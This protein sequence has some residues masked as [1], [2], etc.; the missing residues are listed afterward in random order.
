MKDNR[1]FGQG[2]N[3]KVLCDLDLAKGDI[4][5]SCL[6]NSRYSLTFSSSSKA[7]ILSPISFIVNLFFSYRY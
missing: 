4:F 7:L 6:C 1:Y 2:I 3:T 5:L